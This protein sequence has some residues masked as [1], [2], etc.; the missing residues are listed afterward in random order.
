MEK[1][2]EMAKIVYEWVSKKEES[3]QKGG[4]TKKE[5]YNL[6]IEKKQYPQPM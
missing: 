3:R 6:H 4:N 1:I 2:K 5:H